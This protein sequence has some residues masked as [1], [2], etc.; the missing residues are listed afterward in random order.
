[1]TL[2]NGL[3]VVVAVLVILSTA[4]QEWQYRRLRR[5]VTDLAT[6]TGDAFDEIIGGNDAN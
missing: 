2:T 5:M 4:R 3:L 6:M 1:M